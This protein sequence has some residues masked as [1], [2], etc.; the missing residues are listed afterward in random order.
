MSFGW[1]NQGLVG[2]GEESWTM[3]QWH[4]SEAFQK[5]S[6]PEATGEKLKFGS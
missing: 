3:N 5:K 6:N 1:R 2:L 4:C